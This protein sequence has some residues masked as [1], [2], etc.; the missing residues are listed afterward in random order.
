MLKIS[1]KLVGA[2]LNNE[3]LHETIM[4]SLGYKNFTIKLGANSCFIKSNN[5]FH[6]FA[7][8]FHSDVLHTYITLKNWES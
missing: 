4:L 7:M 1:C 8:E 3:V 6:L 2:F 5:V